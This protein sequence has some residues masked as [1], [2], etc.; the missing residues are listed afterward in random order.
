MSI[1]DKAKELAANAADKATQAGHAVAGA[2]I[3]RAHV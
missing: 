3:G 2:E 1:F